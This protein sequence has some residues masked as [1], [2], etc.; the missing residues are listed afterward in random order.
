MPFGRLGTV[1]GLGGG[2]ELQC[3]SLVSVN[4]AAIVSAA[5]P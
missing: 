3:I 2:E 5:F 4:M 1:V